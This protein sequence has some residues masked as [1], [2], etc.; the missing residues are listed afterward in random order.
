[1]KTSHKLISVLLAFA[2]LVWTL[3]G[4]TA[5]LSPCLSQAV[6]RIKVPVFPDQSQSSQFSYAFQVY[7]SA[8]PT[9]TTIV[10]LPGGP[11]GTL[12]DHSPAELYATGA[13]PAQFFN[14]V[15]IDPRGSGCNDSLALPTRSLK[16]HY[17]ARDV[18]AVISN[19]KLNNYIIYGVSFGTV[20]ATQVA[21]MI[22]K[23]PLPKPKAIVLEGTFGRA[24]PQRFK[25]YA[26]IFSDQWTR[27]QPDIDAQVLEGLRQPTLPLGFSSLA[28]GLLFFN[29]L[30]SG[31]V[32][33]KGSLL[34]LD[35]QALS[36]QEPQAL[37][38]LKLKLSQLPSQSV[39]LQSRLFRT[40]GCQELFPSWG[41]LRLIQGE[42]VPVEQPEIC[43]GLA[44][45]RPYDA[46]AWKISTPIYY[47]QGPYDPATPV[48]SARYHFASQT[49]AP[50]TFITV[51]EAAHAPL[52]GSL[53]VLNCSQ[54]LWWAIDR[55]PLQL[56]AAADS[57]NWP[58][59]IESKKPN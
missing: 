5:P 32:P 41:H 3:E 57:C 48:P 53:K 49:K 16:S 9:A 54:N 14:L 17:S 59:T 7:P 30:T 35:L 29:D 45:Q 22:E 1:M 47:F 33:G 52:T 46:A 10:V 8:D 50:R 13:I 55:N 25:D 23:S 51:S 34:A 36:T 42:L 6:R 58:I 24:I 40:I 38:N 2:C 12:L 39:P 43:Q 27:I 15:Y 44:L 19:L 4:L 11:G 21:S 20:L 56:K 26:K 37:A 31:H 28:Y 18:V